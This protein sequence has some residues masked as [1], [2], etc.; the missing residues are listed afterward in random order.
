MQPWTELDADRRCVPGWP[1]L[2]LGLLGLLALGLNLGTGYGQ[3]QPVPA[4]ADPAA[5]PP[6]GQFLSLPGTIDDAVY[7]RVS[8]AALALQARALQE[9]RRGILVLEISPGS[10]Q[11]H[12]INGLAKFLAGEL[13]SIT[14]VAWVPETVTGNHVILALACQEI[15]MAPDASLGD[16][17]LGTPLDQDEQ[18]FVVNLANR[19]HN[20]KLSEAL[21]LGLLDRQKEMLWVHLEHGEKPNATREARIVSRA[22]YDDLARTGVQILDVKTIKEAG[23]PGV[24]SGERARAYDML[25]MHTAKSREEVGNL[26]RL[27][28]EAMREDHTAGEAPRA[29]VIKIDGMIEP[30]LEQFVMRQ[31]DRAVGAG[32]NLIIFEIESPGGYLR[33]SLDLANAIADLHGKKVRSVAFIPRE[34]LSGAA[35]IALGADEI[36]MTDGGLI[37]DAGPIEVGE[38]QQFERAPEKILSM[39]R[40]SLKGLAERK[41]RPPALAMAMADK[42]L[43]VFEATHSQTGHVTFM[44]DDEIHNSN[45]EWVKGRQVPES[46]QGKLLTLDGRRAHA[47]QLAEPPVR[48]FPDLKARLGVPAEVDVRVSTRTWVDTMIFILNNGW[49]TTLLFIVGIMCIYFELHIPTG[50]FGIIS[51]V[52]FGL[53][54][55]S[56]FLGGTAGWLEVVLFLLGAGCLAI[57]FFVLPGFGVFGVSGVLLCLFS[58]ILASQTFVIPASAGDLQ[59]FARSVGTL[60]GAVVGTAVLAAIVSRYLPSIPL[61]NEMILTPP[62]GDGVA[63]EPKLRPELIGAAASNPLLE[64]DRALVGKQGTSLTV[65]RPA[66]KAKIGDD[67]IDVISDGP[68][69]SSGRQ[70]EVVEVSGNRVVVR[71]LT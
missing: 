16:I 45:G 38:G 49:V 57:E 9:R 25:V 66:G 44:T 37:G 29:I 59:V 17:S 24:F 48:D 32:V 62:G 61:F 5:K 52:C 23:T 7:G 64:R 50:F 35:I 22:G 46:G 10:S 12:Q 6:I 58:L 56:R 34:A 28:R 31:I 69:I 63:G 60:S 18:T 41:N 3:D 11:F 55:W 2:L 70:I 33:Q 14:T 13:P 26:Y 43:S 19:R 36:Y 53:F 68:F 4:E 47:V 65:L 30:I 20:R 40:T 15:V 71:E 42:D 1:L 21:V 51:C 27:P 67:F 39:L 54:F 8:R